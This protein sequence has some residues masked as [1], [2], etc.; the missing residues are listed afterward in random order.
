MRYLPALALAA[1][2]LGPLAAC[3]SFVQGAEGPIDRVV[4]DSLDNQ[5]SVPFLITGVKEA[6]NDTFDQTA[7]LAS[8]L[9]DEGLFDT[10]V[11]NASYITY[12]EIDDGEIELDNNSVD[13]LY[14]DLNEYRFLADDLLRRAEETIEFSEDADGAEARRAAT[15]AGNLHGGIA[16]YLLATYF[17][18]N[19]TEGGA[20][21]TTDPDSPGPFIPSAQL[22]DQ[23]ADKLA[24]ALA[25]ASS[26]YERRLVNSL[27]A[28]NALYAGDPTL[29]AT[30]AAAGLVEGDDPY[31]ARYAST[32]QNEWYVF[33]GRGRTQVAV[34]PRFQAYDEGGD[35]RVQVEPAPTTSGVTVP[36]YR[37]AL[38]TD[39]SG[40]DPLPFISWQE[41]ALIRA[42]TA[43]SDEEALAFVNAIR[44]E[45][46]LEALTS[47]TPARLR[48][49][50][51]RALFTL[52]A[53]LVDQRRFGLPFTNLDGPIGPWRYFPIPEGE[54]NANPNI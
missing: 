47:I 51:D 38:Y 37:Q 34:D 18:L 24:A 53:R 49:E 50:R 27:L 4:S 30:F 21:I 26:D 43:A 16:R 54:R 28:R 3:D 25:V 23:A 32:S 7:L 33:G 52:G 46:G 2:T 44:A 42:E 19:P 11:Q 41:T 1:L 48:E 35:P 5:A 14:E 39:P 8:L 31:L 9:S 29:A 36:F 12:Q 20:I 45:A 15:Y 40:A 10:R 6:F 17:G 13:G 22:Y